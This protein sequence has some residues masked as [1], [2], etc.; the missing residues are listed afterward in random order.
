M[1]K[2]PLQ[3]LQADVSDEKQQK[4]LALIDKNADRMLELVDQ[5]LE[6]SK[7]D[8]GALRLILK[9]GNIGLF[10]KSVAEPFAYQAKERGFKYSS[11]IEIPPENHRF[12]KDVVEKIVTNLLSNALKYT[13]ENQRISF[14]STVENEEL[15]INI[16]NSV[17]GIQKSDLPKIF[18]RFYQNEDGQEGFGV[19]LALVKELVELYNGKLNTS[20]AD[21]VLN[22]QITLPLVQD[23]AGSVFVPKDQINGVYEDHRPETG[24]GHELPVL[25]IVDDNTEIRNLLMDLFSESYMVLEAENGKDALKTAQTEIPDCIISDVMMP[26]M[27]GF[28]FTRSIKSNELTSFI[29]VILLTAKSSEGTHLES[30]RSTADAFLIKPFHNEI[31]KETVVRQISERKKLRERYSRELILRP[32]DIAIN[33][34]DEK[35]LEKLGVVMERH[36]SDTNFS[37]DDFASELGMS[38]MQLHRKLKSLLNVSTTEF[39]RNERLKSAVELI[40]K[41][42]KGV[43]E[44]AYAV[45]FNDVSYFSKCFKELYSVTP[46]EYIQRI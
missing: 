36:M 33:T 26:G 30:L 38:R 42:H 6:L 20:L 19:G 18:E 1:I 27:D 15:E 24:P 9:E 7:L 35:F 32:V 14:S 22:F 5:L 4:R 40:R 45:G 21:K 46:T 39:I 17:R 31:L 23:E 12:D 25:L 29:P 2:S 10:L 28:E 34:V 8:S 13:P 37:T 44:V 41:G 11:D 3:S 43:S 16:S